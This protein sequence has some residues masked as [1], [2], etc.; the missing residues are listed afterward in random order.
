M[1]AS[2]S[3][4]NWRSSWRE[5]RG[6]GCTPLKYHKNAEFG[7]DKTGPKPRMAKRIA[8]YDA[9]VATL[10]ER[11]ALCGGSGN[12]GDAPTRHCVRSGAP[13]VERCD[14]CGGKGNACAGPDRDV[15]LKRVKRF[16]K[17]Y[18]AGSAANPKACAAPTAAPAPAPGDSPRAAAPG[19]DVNMDDVVDVAEVEDAPRGPKVGPNIRDFFATSI[20][21]S[22]GQEQPFPSS[23]TEDELQDAVHAAF[24][25]CGEILA[26][27]IAT[28]RETGACLGLCHVDFDS[29]KAAD[30]AVDIAAKTTIGGRPI[31]VNYSVPKGPQCKLDCKRVFFGTELRFVAGVVI[32]N[33][34]INFEWKSELTGNWRR[35][36]FQAFDIKSIVYKT[37][38]DA[39]GPIDLAGDDAPADLS[40]RG[41]VVEF[42]ALTLHESVV[43][44]FS[45]SGDRFDPSQNP[46]PHCH[47]VLDLAGSAARV[48]MDDFLPS[49]YHFFS[50]VT[51]KPISGADAAAPYLLGTTTEMA[52]Q[53]DQSINECL[54]CDEWLSNDD[55]LLCGAIWSG[56][57]GWPLC[58]TPGCRNV[59]CASCVATTGLSVGDL[60]YCPACAGGGE[61]AAATSTTPITTTPITFGPEGTRPPPAPVA[62]GPSRA[63]EEPASLWSGRVNT[64]PR[65]LR[66]AQTDLYLPG[67]RRPEEHGQTCLKGHNH[68]DMC[69]VVRVR[70]RIAAIVAR[71]PQAW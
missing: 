52:G 68:Y 6:N 13:C 29:D 1:D 31:C 66:P 53:H 33:Q 30:T 18:P 25:F 67:G 14:A 60:F 61:S 7:H 48:F 26:I 41:P 32:T 42:L 51:I 21:I 10:A 35:V 24:D 5:I 62:I 15:T 27:R 71:E 45:L 28:D 22:I 16:L 69:G 38:D 40:D 55:C 64:A 11:C 34:V 63:S 70:G 36:A 2:A 49:L 3:P 19:V 56:E 8:Q 44:G 23:V 58:D 46:G 37:Q 12:L 65:P 43:P 57:A 59:C 20:S 17:A 4:A 50:H 47:V 9:D 39:A 54:L